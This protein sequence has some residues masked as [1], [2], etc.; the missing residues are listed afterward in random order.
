MK[1]DAEL[2]ENLLVQAMESPRLRMSFDLRTSPDDQS[3]RILNALIPG[4]VLPIHRHRASAETVILLKGDMDEIFYDEGG[5]ETG[6]IHLN[7]KEG[8][9]G[10]QIPQGEWHG[11]EVREPSVI[12]E[13]KDG[14]YQPLTSED[15]L[16]ISIK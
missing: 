13:A 14:A 1:I 7:H 3:Q 8:C 10:A 5:K 9:Y 2:M 12:M 11:I 16:E 6:R 4:T 15:I